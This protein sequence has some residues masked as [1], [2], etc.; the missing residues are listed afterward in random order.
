MTVDKLWRTE[1]TVGDELTVG[2]SQKQ[3][4]WGETLKLSSEQNE[5]GRQW[6][7]GFENTP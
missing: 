7:V 4:V 3:P 2:R 5:Q 6:M 1:N